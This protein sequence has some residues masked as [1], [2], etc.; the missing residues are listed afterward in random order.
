MRVLWFVLV[1]I[2]T[3]QCTPL[4]LVWTRN[5]DHLHLTVD[6]STECTSGDAQIHVRVHVLESHPRVLAPEVSRA[7]HFPMV[8]GVSIALLI[9]VAGDLLVP[10]EGTREMMRMKILVRRYVMQSNGGTAC[11]RLA[12]F[13]HLILLAFNRPVAVYV[14]LQ[15]CRRD[16]LL[17]TSGPVFHVMGV[18]S[19]LV[20]VV[21]ELNDGP[22]SNV[23][24]LGTWKSRIKR[25]DKNGRP[26]TKY[27]TMG[28]VSFRTYPRLSE[29]N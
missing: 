17:T 1:N 23:L 11:D 18:Q 26:R 24:G 21:Q 20:G 10:G 27:L 4:R 19:H 12:A 2:H 5:S 29:L 9:A 13:A 16:R 6:G 22:A 7:D 8:S 3:L 28:H 14:V 25:G 15:F